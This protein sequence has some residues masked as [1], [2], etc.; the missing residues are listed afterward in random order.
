MAERRTRARLRPRTRLMTSGQLAPKQ[1]RAGQP[2]E[3]KDE[4]IEVPVAQVAISPHPEPGA[5]QGA[6]QRYQEK[7]AELLGKRARKR[8]IYEG[9]RQ[10]R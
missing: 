10:D 2:N 7:P 3:D 5:K 6:G 1:A 9:G 8:V 4:G